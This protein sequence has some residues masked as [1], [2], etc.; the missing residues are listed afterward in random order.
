[1]NFRR[2]AK[3]QDQKQEEPRESRFPRR[4]NSWTIEDVLPGIYEFGK[5]QFAEVKETFVKPPKITIAPEALG[6]VAQI[7]SSSFV[8]NWSGAGEKP[9]LTVTITA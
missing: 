7:T 9:K 6:K 1:M 2:D 3:E 5:G 4:A 8:L